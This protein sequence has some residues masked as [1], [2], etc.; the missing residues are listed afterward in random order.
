VLCALALSAAA[1]LSA[2]E[3]AGFV[4]DRMSRATLYALLLALMCV[5]GACSLGFIGIGLRAAVEAGSPVSEVYVG[6][7]VEWLVQAFGAL[8][9]QTATCASGFFP[10]V[11]TAWLAVALICCARFPLSGGSAGGS[12]TLARALLE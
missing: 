9:T 2:P 7:S 12:E 1:L 4:S 8:L 3:A 10:C 11:G 5:A 6:G